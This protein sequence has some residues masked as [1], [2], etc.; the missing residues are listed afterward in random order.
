MDRTVFFG[1]QRNCNEEFCSSKRAS[2]TADCETLIIKTSTDGVISSNNVETRDA[3]DY[4]DATNTASLVPLLMELLKIFQLA[5]GACWTLSV[6][7][8]QHRKELKSE[9]V[10]THHRRQLF[11]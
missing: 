9:N 3:P 10:H 6:S 8:M 7:T 2:K 4:S 1:G 11:S 5:I